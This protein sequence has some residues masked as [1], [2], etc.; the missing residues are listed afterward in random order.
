MYNVCVPSLFMFGGEYR[1]V[2]DICVT[3]CGWVGAWVWV[4]VFSATWY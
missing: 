4:P 1:F 3:V 2:C